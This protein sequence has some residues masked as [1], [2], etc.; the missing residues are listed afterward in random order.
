MRLAGA[1]LTVALAWVVL[2][3]GRG[4]ALASA[5]PCAPTLP[6]RVVQP[7]AA[8][9]AAGFNFG[10]AG[11]RVQLGWPKGTLAAGIL[12][13]GGSRATVE[14]DGSIHAKLGWWRGVAGTLR[15]A[16]RRLDSSAPPL[17]A[18]VPAGYG[19]RGFQPTGLVFPTAGCWRVV[20]RVGEARLTYDV[21]VTRLPRR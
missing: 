9:R 2:G 7:T 16:A 3:A 12:P 1:A 14:D 17:G 18:D 6:T 21:S 20:G 19:R 4:G 10:N 13:D 15:V 5:S 11:L 8:P